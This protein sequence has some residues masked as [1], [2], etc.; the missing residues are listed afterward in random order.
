MNRGLALPGKC[1]LSVAHHM[2]RY[3]H[4][5]DTVD[6]SDQEETET[7]RMWRQ[8]DPQAHNAVKAAYDE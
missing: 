2:P 6:I 5:I 8:I 4:A 7:E 3:T 1:P